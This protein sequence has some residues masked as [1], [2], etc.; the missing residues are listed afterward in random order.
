MSCLCRE[1]YKEIL[2]TL[3]SFHKGAECVDSA[4][5][6]QVLCQ[7]TL[8]IFHRSSITLSLLG[9]REK[10]IFYKFFLQT[11]KSVGRKSCQSC[12]RCTAWLVSE[13]TVPAMLV[14]TSIPRDELPA[15]DFSGCYFSHFPSYNKFLLSLH[16]AGRK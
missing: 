13:V 10:S 9:N 7:K 11:S 14:M 4:C 6:P 5:F 2:C 8:L 15:S 16:C 3:Y 12:L 1:F